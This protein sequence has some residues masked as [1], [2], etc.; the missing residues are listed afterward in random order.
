MDVDRKLGSGI[1]GELFAHLIL[2]SDQD[3]LDPMVLGSPHSSLHNTLRGKIPSHGIHSDLHLLIL[4]PRVKRKLTAPLPQER[5][6]SP[7]K[8]RSGGRYGEGEEVHGI[9]GRG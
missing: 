6:L 8:N 1:L 3:N 4:I 9:A 5:P 2:I 7:C